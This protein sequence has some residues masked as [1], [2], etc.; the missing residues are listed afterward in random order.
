[1]RLR[2]LY[3]INSRRGLLVS[4]LFHVVVLTA[5]ATATIQLTT[6]EGFVSDGEIVYGQESGGQ[7]TPVE[8]A[9]AQPKGKPN[10]EEQKIPEEDTVV[11]PTKQ[12]AKAE[13]KT[14]TPAPVI[15]QQKVEST[16]DSD[17]PVK[18]EEKIARKETKKTWVPV[19]E[20]DIDDSAGGTLGSKTETPE[21]ESE[22]AAG[23]EDGETAASDAGQSGEGSGPVHSEKELKSLPGNTYKYPLMARVQRLEGTV[24]IRFTLQPSGEVA[25]VWV[26]QSSGSTLLD[27][28]ALESHAKWKYE[29]GIEGVVQ[30]KVIFSLK[31]PAELMPYRSN[32]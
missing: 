32:N 16:D 11:V 9:P 4:I 10:L 25:K 19:E 21:E 3:R 5:L 12:K 31:G 22:P 26:Q 27:R 8:I 7:P 24:V 17:V 28:A 20:T 29:E 1:M 15:E 6:P 2:D 13:T 14:E 18:T 30:K 23:T